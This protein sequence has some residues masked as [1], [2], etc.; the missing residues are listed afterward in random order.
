M[1]TLNPVDEFAPSNPSAGNTSNAPTLDISGTDSSNNAIPAKANN[2]VVVS[3]QTSI[4]VQGD[5][6]LIAVSG[7]LLSNVVVAQVDLSASHLYVDASHGVIEFWESSDNR[8]TIHACISASGNA[9]G[10]GKSAQFAGFTDLSGD[11]SGGLHGV[12]NGSLN[13]SAA[14]P[15]NGYGATAEYNT[16]ASLGDMVLGLYAH[17]LFGHVAAT[18]AI[19]NDAALVSYMNGSSGAAVGA[20]LTEAL[21]AMLPAVARTIA[22]QVLSQ[23][24]SRARGQ[25]NNAAQNESHQ[26][27][28]FAPGDVVYV[29]IAVD[30]PTINSTKADAGTDSARTEGDSSGAP[31]SGSANNLVGSAYPSTSPSFAIQI[32]LN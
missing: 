19:D 31:A 15:F 17:Y 25:D 4:S 16:F 6:D 28:L 24:P 26:A 30:A 32:T 21:S 22:S 1:A 5:V 11:L 18:A 29:Q 14:T 8:G 27:L 10:D 2:R 3:L 20:N 23:D 12:I 9:G 7:E 13:A